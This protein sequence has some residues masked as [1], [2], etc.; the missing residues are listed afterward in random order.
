[1]LSCTA[2]CSARSSAPLLMSGRTS[3][4]SLSGICL[5]AAARRIASSAS[6]SGSPPERAT[7]F[8]AMISCDFTAAAD[9]GHNA[10]MR[11][12]VNRNLRDARFQA[13]PR[14]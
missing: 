8:V 2:G 9:A 13:W 7:L 3:S 12:S 1:V 4:S 6:T 10:D 11:S 14:Q 5:A